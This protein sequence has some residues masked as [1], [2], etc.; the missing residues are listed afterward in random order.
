MN[1]ILCR[2]WC[3]WSMVVRGPKI[4]PTHQCCEISRRPPTSAYASCGL[5][6]CWATSSPRPRETPL[7]HAGWGTFCTTSQKGVMLAGSC[8]P[9]GQA[10]LTALHHLPSSFLSA[11]T[12]TVPCSLLLTHS[13]LLRPNA[14]Y[15][16]PVITVIPLTE[17]AK[18]GL[19]SSH[20]LQVQNIALLLKAGE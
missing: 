12:N 17:I 4:S 18:T 16:C 15:V 20:R 3:L 5:A 6:P 14:R 10:K 2:L 9:F 13:S 8:F 1:T 11:D 19:D 7:S